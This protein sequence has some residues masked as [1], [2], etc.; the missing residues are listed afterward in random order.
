MGGSGA[1]STGGAAIVPVVV[2]VGG[3]GGMMVLRTVSPP[4][5]V[6]CGGS[7]ATSGVTVFSGPLDV[8]RSLRGRWLWDVVDV[9]VDVLVAVLGDMLGVVGDIPAPVGPACAGVLVKPVVVMLSPGLPAALAPP[10]GCT[11]PPV[12]AEVPLVMLDEAPPVDAVAE[13]G[14]PWGVAVPLALDILS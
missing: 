11:S 10:A 6:G 2:A 4:D 14:G 7:A 1:G 13:A 3:G 12:V 9:P 8:T 5:L